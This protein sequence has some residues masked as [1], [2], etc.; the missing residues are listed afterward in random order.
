MTV[1]PLASPFTLRDATLTVEADDYTAAV[2]QAQFDPTT[3]TA[4][5]TGIGG[6]VVQD[7][8]PTT[9]VLTLAVAQDLDPAGLSRYLHENVGQRK[10]VTLTPKSLGP[11]VTATVI[12]APVAIGG[13]ADGNLATGTVGLPVDGTPEFSD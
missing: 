13:T 6:N 2:S 9:W 3:N 11:S 1:K 12:L 7:V 5:W 10:T 8:S 4:S